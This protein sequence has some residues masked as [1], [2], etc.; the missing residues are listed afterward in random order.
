MTGRVLFEVLKLDMANPERTSERGVLRA[1]LENDLSV[2][3][4]VV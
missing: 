4:L 2:L 1:I 3:D